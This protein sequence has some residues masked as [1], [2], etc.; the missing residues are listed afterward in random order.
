MGRQILRRHAQHA[1]AMACRQILGRA[2]FPQI[3]TGAEAGSVTGDLHAAN[4]RVHG[5]QLESLG[6]RIPHV[7]RQR[8][9][10]LRTVQH[11]LEDVFV[12]IQQ[13]G[14]CALGF[15]DLAAVLRALARQPCGEFAAALQRS[16]A[17][18]LEHQAL[19]DVQ[20]SHG[21]QNLHQ[22]R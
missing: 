4:A 1:N 16:V 7:H 9:A 6:Q 22:H 11:H 13:H 8:V 19:G 2:K 15:A 17:E 12:T 20:A 5:D 21:P 18:G 3:A 14:R 10:I